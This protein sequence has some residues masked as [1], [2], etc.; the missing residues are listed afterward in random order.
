MEELILMVT[1]SKESDEVFQMTG[2]LLSYTEQED[3]NEGIINV[4]DD[5]SVAIL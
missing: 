4:N 3:E 5:G 1:I 2:N